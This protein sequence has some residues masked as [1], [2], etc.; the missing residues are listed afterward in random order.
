MKISGL[1]LSNMFALTVAVNCQAAD[2]PVKVKIE[3]NAPYE[4]DINKAELKEWQ[5]KNKAP[6]KVVLA[7]KAGLPRMVNLGAVKDWGVTDEELRTASL[8]EPLRK[9]DITIAALRSFHLGDT[10]VSILSGTD[11]WYFPVI[12]NEEIKLILIVGKNPPSADWE[13]GAFGYDVLARNLNKIMQQWPQSKGY[14]PV[15]IEAEHGEYFFT[16]PEKDYSNLTLIPTLPYMEK[17]STY[18]DLDTVDNVVSWL[19]PEFEEYVRQGREE[20]KAMESIDSQYKQKQL[21]RNPLQRSG[22]K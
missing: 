17:K 21:M 22:D 11:Y 9:Y 13:T 19:R 2:G 15:V 7:A 3:K 4:I 8:G 6:L 1:I 18:P 12:I 14:H 5:K 10:V 16:V 20:R